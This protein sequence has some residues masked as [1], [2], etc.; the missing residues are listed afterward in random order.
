MELDNIGLKF[1]VS[2]YLQIYIGCWVYG[3]K[4]QIIVV[5]ANLYRKMNSPCL[6][7][8]G[9]FQPT[10][11]VV[12]LHYGSQ[13]LELSCRSPNLLTPAPYSEYFGTAEPTHELVP[14][15]TDLVRYRS[16]YKDQPHKL[17]T[18]GQIDIVSPIDSLGTLLPVRR[19]TDPPPRMSGGFVGL[20]YCKRYWWLSWKC[21]CNCLDS[22]SI[23]S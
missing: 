2:R 18:G 19:C 11:S 23:D 22:T 17:F 7:T 14:P 6:A 21:Q 3:C 4:P 15:D 8:N 16:S 12:C 10:L 20:F 1:T 13:A 9:G 5:R